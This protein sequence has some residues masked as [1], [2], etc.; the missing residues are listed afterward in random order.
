VVLFTEL[1][2][3]LIV[4]LKGEAA[5][6]EYECTDC[7]EMFHADEPAEDRDICDECRKEERKSNK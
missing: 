5:M 1:K 6:G 7:N 3:F 4:F 2:R